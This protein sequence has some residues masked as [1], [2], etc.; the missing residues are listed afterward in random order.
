MDDIMKER[1]FDTYLMSA[2]ERLVK[3]NV[4][5]NIEKISGCLW[6]DNDTVHDLKKTKEIIYPGIAKK[7]RK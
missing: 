5:L 1:A 6:S 3:K 2:F 4:S 7:A